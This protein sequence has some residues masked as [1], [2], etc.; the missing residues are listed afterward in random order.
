MNYSCSSLLVQ[1]ANQ[2][3]SLILVCCNNGSGALV[4]IVESYVNVVIAG[5]GTGFGAE[6]C[7]LGG[8]LF[9][10][11][12]SIGDAQINLAFFSKA[13]PGSYHR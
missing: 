12:F 5:V 6:K 13:R 3:V 10:T 8:N 2:D 9:A 7:G 4:R 1:K 11:A